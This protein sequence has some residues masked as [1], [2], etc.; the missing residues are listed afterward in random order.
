MRE[1]H[2]PPQAIL[3]KP[4]VEEHDVYNPLLAWQ[5]PG[6]EACGRVSSL[7]CPPTLPG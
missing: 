3:F 7:F 1:L 2:Y 6:L 4:E 5:V